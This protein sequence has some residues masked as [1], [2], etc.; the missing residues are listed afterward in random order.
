MHISVINNKFNSCLLSLVDFN[1]SVRFGNYYKWG[2]K[3][4]RNP[5]D[6]IDWFLN[7]EIVSLTM[8]FWSMML[9]C[10]PNPAF[11]WTKASHSL[12]CL[13]AFKDES[14]LL[15]RSHVTME[16]L[17]SEEF[18]VHDPCAVWLNGE[19]PCFHDLLYLRWWN[20]YYLPIILTFLVLEMT[21]N[22]SER[23]KWTNLNE[24]QQKYCY[25]GN[26]ESVRC[27]YWG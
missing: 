4:K 26:C 16:D 22:N 13:S 24:T 5:L 8:L 1:W 21:W 25:F 6:W 9:K 17:E 14:H 2:K 23:I 12:L 7:P 27:R 11:M 15:L 18:K 10:G 20:V 19:D 3:K